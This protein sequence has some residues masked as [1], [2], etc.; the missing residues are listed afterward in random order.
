MRG[1]EGCERVLYVEEG[2]VGH[3][4]SGDVQWSEQEGSYN[5]ERNKTDLPLV[6]V[7]RCNADTCCFCKRA[8]GI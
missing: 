3:E 8:S 6:V 2:K 4:K 7:K 1:D 5:G